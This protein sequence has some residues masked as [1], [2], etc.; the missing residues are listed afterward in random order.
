[1]VLTRGK[2]TRLNKAFPG[3]ICMENWSSVLSE[4]DTLMCV[5][6]IAKPVF[7]TESS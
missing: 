6:P 3:T 1:M 2:E 5:I 7:C 4:C